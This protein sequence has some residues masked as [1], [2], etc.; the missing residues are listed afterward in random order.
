MFASARSAILAAVDVQQA[1][2][3]T[4]PSTPTSRI[5]LRIG[6]HT[7]EIVDV[8]GDV[9]GQNVIV[10]VRIADHAAARARSWCRA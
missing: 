10:A 8:D 3:P 7:G 4:A 5:D 9:F 6:L 2:P 1:L